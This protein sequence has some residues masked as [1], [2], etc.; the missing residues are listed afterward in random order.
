VEKI[1]RKRS[2]GRRNDVDKLK[3]A[4]QNRVRW[5]GVVTAL[6]SMLNPGSAEAQALETKKNISGAYVHTTT[7]ITI[8]RSAT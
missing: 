1:C 7:S 6:C 3:K 2:E 8:T 4:A 5:Q